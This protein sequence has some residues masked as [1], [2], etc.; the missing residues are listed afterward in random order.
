MTAAAEV[1]AALI[2]VQAATLDAARDG[3]KNVA[4]VQ[5]GDARN[6]L[7]ERLRR[8]LVESRTRRAAGG[9]R[10]KKDENSHPRPQQYGETCAHN[11]LL[12]SVRLPQERR[13]R[14]I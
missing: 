8:A 7:R 4:C 11:L 14:L 12:L 6:C 10:R 2:A 3:G 5:N 1:A 9:D 13:R